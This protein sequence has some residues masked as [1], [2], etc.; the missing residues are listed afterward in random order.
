MVKQMSIEIRRKMLD[1]QYR[2]KT[3]NEILLAPISAINGVSLQDE[4]HLEQAL[5]VRTIKDLSSNRFIRMALTIATL[6]EMEK[7]EA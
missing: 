6:A 4:E 3:W 2:D 7:L 1:K 5:N